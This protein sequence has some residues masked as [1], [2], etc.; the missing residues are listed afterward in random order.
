MLILT[1][2]VGENTSIGDEISVSILGIKGN[3][4]RIGF[5]APRDIAIHR[6]EA[7]VKLESPKGFVIMDNT[8][9][10]SE[11]NDMGN[12]VDDALYGKIEVPR[13]EF[14]GVKGSLQVTVSFIPD[15][16]VK[17]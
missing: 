8:Y 16:E 1:R 5:H 13:D 3:Q 11:F 6:E 7:K 15:S 10:P 9:D 2:K 12:D 17:I 14:D 4:V